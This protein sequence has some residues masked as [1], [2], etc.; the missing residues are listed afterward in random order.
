MDTFF[1]FSEPYPNVVNFC[2]T[3]WQDLLYNKEECSLSEVHSYLLQ[4]NEQQL[5]VEIKTCIKICMTAIMSFSLLQW[6][7]S[8]KCQLHV[9]ALHKE[10]RCASYLQDYCADVLDT[11]DY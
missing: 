5:H 6:Q 8:N 7:S 10:R 4:L 1:E 9:G 11:L 3:P 2:A